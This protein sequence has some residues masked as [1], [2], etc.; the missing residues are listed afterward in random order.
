MI[1]HFLFRLLPDNDDIAMPDWFHHYPTGR[2]LGVMIFGTADRPYINFLY[3]ITVY[4]LLPTT[5]LSPISGITPSL[6]THH[7]YR[8]TR[9]F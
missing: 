3:F 6:R 9:R 7:E 2:I 4:K 5:P 8:E 1:L